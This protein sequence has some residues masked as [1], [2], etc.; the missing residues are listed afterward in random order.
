MDHQMG[1]AFVDMYCRD[2]R[3]IFF[4]DKRTTIQWYWQIVE[5]QIYNTELVRLYS[6]WLDLGLSKGCGWFWNL[7]GASWLKML[8][9]QCETNCRYTFVLVICHPFQRQNWGHNS[10][11]GA[12]NVVEII[13]R[14]AGALQTWVGLTLDNCQ[15]VNKTIMT[16]QQGAIL[17]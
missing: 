13:W 11:W 16:D 2:L 10:H 4:S 3:D 6:V 9:A 7:L 17:N 12:A 8:V 5:K 14:P 1:L 15:K